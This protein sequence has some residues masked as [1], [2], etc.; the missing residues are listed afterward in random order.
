VVVQLGA[1][2]TVSIVS[3]GIAEEWAETD[4]P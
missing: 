3:D 2:R 4:W 1:H